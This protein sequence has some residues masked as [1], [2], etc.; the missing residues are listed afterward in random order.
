[1]NYFTALKI[2]NQGRGSY[3]SPKKGTPE[4]AAVVAIQN[5]GAAPASAASA[6]AK[7]NM[8]PMPSKERIA[9]LK[10]KG[11]ALIA[12]RKADAAAALA[13]MPKAKPPSAT[14]VKMRRSRKTGSAVRMAVPKPENDVSDPADPT[15]GGRGGMKMRNTRRKVKIAIPEASRPL[16]TTEFSRRSEPTTQFSSRAGI[17]M[18][19]TLFSTR[20]DGS[21]SVGS[22]FNQPTV[23]ASAP[24]KTRDSGVLGKEA[25]KMINMALKGKIARNKMKAAEKQML[26]DIFLQ[27]PPYQ[28]KHVPKSDIF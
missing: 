27:D 18:G 4:H 5:G 6:A 28:F 2:Y 1:M 24:S 23:D 16:P 25:G 22:M 26:F 21:G 19:T 20:S 3:C 15:G 8:P 9:E 12:Q 10:A 14:G 11:R 13:A 7:S 17:Q